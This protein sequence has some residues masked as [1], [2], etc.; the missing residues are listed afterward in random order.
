MATIRDPAATALDPGLAGGRFRQAHPCVP[1]R[2]AHY[3]D[4]TV[5]R[6]RVLKIAAWIAAAVSA[7]FGAWQTLGGFGVWQLGLVNLVTGLVFVAIPVL[8]RFGELVAPLAFIAVAYGSIFFITCSLGTDSGLQFYYLAASS[9]LVLVLGV[10]RIALAGALAGLGALLAV[11]LELTVPGVVGNQPAYT[12]KIGFVTSVVTSCVL[13]FATLWYALREIARAESAME[14]EYDRSERLLTNMLPATIAE[15]LK[16][17]DHESI[18]DRYDDA[19][20]LFADMAGF[21]ERASDTPPGDLVAFLD[22]VYTALDVLVERHGLEKIKTSGDSY[23]VVSGVPRPR[24]DHLQ[25][26]AALAL[27]IASAAAG[28]TDPHGRAVPVRIGLATGP[29]VAGVVGS[30][31]FFYDVWGDAVNVASRM[32]TTDQAGRIQV[33]D[34]V[35]NRLKDEFVLEERGDVAVK[36]KG[37]MHTWYLVSRRTDSVQVDAPV[38]E[39][40]DVLGQ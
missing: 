33:P 32:E 2:S 15:R 18:A 8:H 10:E 9:V 19:S 22:R 37:V 39:Q 5:R 3:V 35:Y 36:G 14:M 21:T 28:L 7:G 24:A 29:V 31:R 16:D 40:V 23:M 34:D 1:V 11:V 17:P 26:L 12:L 25:A 27:D 6:F 20:I 30:R 38:R 4:S 13:A